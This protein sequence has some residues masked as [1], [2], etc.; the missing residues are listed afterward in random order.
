MAVCPRSQ[1]GSHRAADV[2]HRVVNRVAD[3]A[4]VFLGGAGRSADHA[5]LDQRYAERGK[6]QYDADKQ[7]QWQRITY[8][9]EPGCGDGA[10]QKVSSA[11]DEVGQRKCAP[12]AQTVGRGTAEDRKEPDPSTESAGQ[13]ASLL[14]GEVQI[15]LQV[16]CERGERAIIGKPLEDLSNVRDPEGPLETGA[17]FFPA[18][19]KTQMWLQSDQ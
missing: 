13:S 6:E 2:D 15:L 7:A 9:R 4:D 18:F 10:N 8:R 14:G 19:R 17:D 11:E 5:R 1:Q 12:E 16:E 3:R